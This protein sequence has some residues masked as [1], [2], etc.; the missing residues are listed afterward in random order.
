MFYPVSYDLDQFLRNNSA[1][2]DPERHTRRRE[3]KD[4]VRGLMVGGKKQVGKLFFNNF[5]C[6]VSV[7]TRLP[8]TATT[9]CTMLKH[10]IHSLAPDLLWACTP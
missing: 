6:R 7:V 4:E 5:S 9:R 3:V 8:L 1:G 2:S 10:P